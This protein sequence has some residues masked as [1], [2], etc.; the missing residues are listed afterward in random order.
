[1]QHKC[2]QNLQAEE[3]EDIQEPER[4][5]APAFIRLLQLPEKSF[6][7]FPEGLQGR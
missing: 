5:T 7:L 1:L 2:L 6:A 3:G 4:E